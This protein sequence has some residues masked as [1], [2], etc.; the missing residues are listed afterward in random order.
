MSPLR[1]LAFW[2]NLH[3]HLAQHIHDPLDPPSKP[4]TLEILLWTLPRAAEEPPRRGDIAR[5]MLA[6]NKNAIQGDRIAVLLSL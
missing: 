2:H 6:K 3:P 5:L 1:S 4:L